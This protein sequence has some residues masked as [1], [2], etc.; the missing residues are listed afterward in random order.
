MCFKDED[1]RTGSD[2]SGKSG[3]R[4]LRTDWP[5]DLGSRGSMESLLRAISPARRGQSLSGVSPGETGRGGS[6]PSISLKKTGYKGE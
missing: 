5:F 6:G 4:G 2:A 3:R 1:A